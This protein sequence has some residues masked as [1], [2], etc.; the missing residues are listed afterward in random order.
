MTIIRTELT[1]AKVVCI[2]TAFL[3]AIAYT[4]VG[5][6]S[7][8]RVVVLELSDVIG[9]ASSDF[10]IRGIDQAERDS[11]ELVVLRIDTPGGL[12]LAMRDIVQKILASTIPIVGYVAP[13]GSRAASAGTYI[14]YATHVAAMAP[15]TNLGA[16]TPVNLAPGGLPGRPGP[17]NGSRKDGEDQSDSGS[18]NGESDQLAPEPSDDSEMPVPSTAMERKMVN[19]AV[20][21]IRGLALMRKRNADWAVAAVREAASLTAEDALEQ[22]VIDLVAPDLNA[23]L[24]R[25]DGRIVEMP[26]GKR[27]LNTKG[28]EIQTLEPDWINRVLS[29]V[30]N[31]NVAYILMLLGVYGLF[32]E[33]SNPGNILPGVAGAVCLLLGLYALHVLPVNYAGLALILLGVAFMV[34]EAFVPSFGALGIG[35]VIAFVVGSMILMD[36]EVANF[37]L[38][39]P[40]ILGFAGTSAAFFLTVIT[41]AVRQRRRPVVTGAEELLGMVGDAVDDFTDQ[42]T[43]RVHGETWRAATNVPIAR[44]QSIRVIARHGLVL[45]V[46]PNAEEH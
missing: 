44:G 39:I 1:T 40:L 22:G 31:P 15:A 27:T 8:P 17:A 26:D 46:E 3:I 41:L 18:A 24:E 25:L 16:A 36:T 5:S 21:Y 43:V 29:I 30:T 28:A 13:Q 23:L 34:G 37:R 6:G 10:V 32:F 35:G 4:T 11:A 9:P 14:L 2:A 19:D 42:G 12:D 20:A 33:I 38:S 45:N 7:T